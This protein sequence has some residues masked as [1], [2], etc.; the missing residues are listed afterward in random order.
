MTSGDMYIGVPFMDFCFWGAIGRFGRGR[1]LRVVLLEEDCEEDWEGAVGWRVLPWRAIILAAP[2]STYLIMPL[3]SRRMST[4]EEGQ[5][6]DQ[7]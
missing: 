4:R 3:W 1:P 6:Q 7:I 5:F 2:K